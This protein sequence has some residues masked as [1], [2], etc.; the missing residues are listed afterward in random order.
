MVQAGAHFAA[1][2]RT[3][4]LQRFRRRCLTVRP[5]FQNFGSPPIEYCLERISN[6]IGR[7]IEQLA[8]CGATLATQPLR[9]RH[10]AGGCTRI[11]TLQRRNSDGIAAAWT[12][13]PAPGH[14]VPRPQT[15]ATT[16]DKL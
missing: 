4:G 1:P 9:R 13:R 8:R 16:T 2:A 12:C 11:G 15:L 10:W 6:L 14:F 5:G 3:F 7:H